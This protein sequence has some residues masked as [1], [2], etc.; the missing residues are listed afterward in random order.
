MAKSQTPADYEKL[1]RELD[2][3]LADLQGDDLDID[4][5]LKSYE[6]GLELV[7]RLEKHLKTAENS[8]RELKANFNKRV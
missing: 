4:Q 2:A 3:I 1:R 7:G 6:R 5:A 8:I